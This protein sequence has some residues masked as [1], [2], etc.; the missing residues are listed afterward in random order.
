MS[1]RQA[2]WR[3]FLK[4]SKNDQGILVLADFFRCCLVVTATGNIVLI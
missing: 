2:D 1:K 3:G 4:K